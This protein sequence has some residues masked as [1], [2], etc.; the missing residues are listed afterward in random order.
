[1]CNGQGLHGLGG[2]V[3]LLLENRLT[4]D[5]ETTGVGGVGKTP[6]GLVSFLWLESQPGT[7][8]KSQWPR[9]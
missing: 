9:A 4:A 2:W 1:M 8:K 6:G 7:E 3:D 5:K